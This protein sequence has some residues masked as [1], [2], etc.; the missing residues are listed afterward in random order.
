[1]QRKDYSDQKCLY[2]QIELISKSRE[3]SDIQLRVNEKRPL[4]TLNRDKNRT[5]IRSDTFI[6]LTIAYTGSINNKCIIVEVDTLHAKLDMYV[7]VSGFPLRERS[8][9]VR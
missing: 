9:P 6:G 5:T 1:M 4:N 3:F 7:F 8:K 2:V